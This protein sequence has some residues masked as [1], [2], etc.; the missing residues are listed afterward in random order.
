MFLNMDNLGEKSLNK[1]AEIALSSQ[2]KQA[3][4]LKVEVKTNP[5]QLSKGILDSLAIDGQGLVMKKNLQMEEMKITLNTI[6]VSPFKALMG[7]IQLTQPSEGTACIIL[8][9]D[10]INSAFQCEKLKKQLEN[11]NIYLENEPVTIEIK[12]I[13]ASIINDGKVSIKAEIL[14]KETNNI[15]KVI[16]ITAPRICATTGKGIS[17]YEIE[18]SAGKELSPLF[19]NAL[20]AEVEK[21]FNLNGFQLEGFSLLINQLNVENG[22][23]RLQGNAGI[24]SFPSV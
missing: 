19:I 24:S 23:L 22:K 13:D 3:N 4:K 20:L 9:E 17:L 21:I 15:E 7:N 14:I 16:L 10:D 12:N 18:C 8:N 1:I 5:T 11:Y 2:L 6:A